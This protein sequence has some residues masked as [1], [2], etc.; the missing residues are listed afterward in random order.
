MQLQR[1]LSR[2]SL[3]V[4]IAAVA[5]DGPWFFY[6]VDESQLE[7]DI[8]TNEGIYR[9]LE[10]AVA[11]VTNNSDQPVFW[12]GACS[13]H[14]ERRPRPEADWQWATGHACI[15]ILGFDPSPLRISPGETVSDSLKVRSPRD[16][17]S[18]EW[19]FRYVIEDAD[20]DV[21]PL[22]QRIS[23]VFVVVEDPS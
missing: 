22:P 9:P 7:I 1:L 5:C 12:H 15:L 13:G 4:L 23:N 16:A 21:L 17:Y 3:L 18:G 8:R 20:G 11:R 6:G 2:R 19:R 10:M 14:L